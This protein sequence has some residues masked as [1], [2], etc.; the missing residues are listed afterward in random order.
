MET[1]AKCETCSMY[2]VD[3]HCR[4]KRSALEKLRGIGR[5]D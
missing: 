1:N 3:V 2:G 4:R 5:E